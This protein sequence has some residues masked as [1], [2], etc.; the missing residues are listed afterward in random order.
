MIALSPQTQIWVYPAP[1]DLREGYNGLYALATE[2]WGATL[3]GDICL[4]VSRRRTSCKILMHDGS[5]L[6]IFIKRLDGSRFARLWRRDEDG[7][8]PLTPSELALFLEG[9]IEVGYRRLSPERA[10]SRT[11]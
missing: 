5:G 11:P 6:A 3:A 9:S 7:N 8:V 10:R 2:P 4:F 1:C